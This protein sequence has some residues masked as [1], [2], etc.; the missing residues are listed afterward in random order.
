MLTF[1][2]VFNNK[3][4]SLITCTINRWASHADYTKFYLSEACFT[5]NAATVI[6]QTLSLLFK[7][8]L[9]IRFHDRPT[10]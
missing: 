10:T 8:F 9:F 7:M 4:P 2:L 1:K 3:A 6:I 5:D